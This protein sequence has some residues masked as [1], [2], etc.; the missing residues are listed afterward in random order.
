MSNLEEI[1]EQ[2]LSE[3]TEESKKAIVKDEKCDKLVYIHFGYRRPKG[4]DYGIFC[5]LVTIDKE[6]K[7]IWAGKVMA[8]NLWSKDSQYITYCQAYWYALRCIAEWQGGLIRNKVGGVLLVTNNQ[9]LN[10]WIQKPEKYKTYGYYM[11]KAI[12]DF[13]VGGKNEIYMS[14]GLLQ[15]R[16]EQA[17][18]YCKEEFVQN[19]NELAKMQGKISSKS[20]YK[21]NIDLS[22]VSSVDEPTIDGMEQVEEL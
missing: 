21:L 22:T 18:K 2:R 8:V 14:V 9:I 7:D 10:K 12:E 17:T 3:Q 20:V 13:A 16:P 6:G 5:A 15:P 19:K 4:C 1:A 11:Q